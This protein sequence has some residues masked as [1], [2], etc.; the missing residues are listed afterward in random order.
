M[1][2][3]IIKCTV[4]YIQPRDFFYFFLSCNPKRKK[5]LMK[6]S[7]RQ[8]VYNY[9]SKLLGNKMFLCFKAGRQEAINGNTLLKSN[10]P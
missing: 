10:K 1:E 8:R 7:G 4:Y 9:Y 5:K 3:A 2:Q 6:R